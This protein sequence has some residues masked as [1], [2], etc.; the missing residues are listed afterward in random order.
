MKVYL[1]VIKKHYASDDQCNNE[2]DIKEEENGID[3]PA[4]RDSKKVCYD[5]ECQY[6]IWKVGTIFENAPRFKDVVAKYMQY[7]RVSN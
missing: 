3:V 6:P 4:R 5:P 1:L 2:S 7:T